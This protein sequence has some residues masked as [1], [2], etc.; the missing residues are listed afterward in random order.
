MRIKIIISLLLLIV[1]VICA[2]QNANAITVRFLFWDATLPVALIIVLT[3]A[4]GV[5]LGLIL[6]LSGKKPA[7][8]V[9][10]KPDDETSEKF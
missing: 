5:I 1:A 9:D 10:K 2:I 7:K 4:V 6:S 3:L 8:A